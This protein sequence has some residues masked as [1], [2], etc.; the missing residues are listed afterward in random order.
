[1][2]FYDCRC[3]VTGVSLKG[4]GAALVLLQETGAGHHPLALP[5]QG[6]YNRLGAI[7]R[8]EEDANAALILRYFLD[9]LQRGQFVVDAE[10]LRPH[11]AFPIENIAQLFAA[12][13]RNINDNSRAAVLNGRPVVFALIARAVW[14]AVASAAPPPS[15]PASTVFQRL[16]K[17]VPAAE[18][19]YRGNVAKVTR[20]LQELSGVHQFLAG[21]GL[22][23][24]PAE[25]A[26]QHSPEEMRAYLDA[27]RQAFRDAP[28]A[29]QG[30]KQYE[31][32]VGEL[33][34]VG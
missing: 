3:M 26:S 22:T 23:W 6:V 15:A 31:A 14:G 13:E 33:L 34:K 28:A 30:L 17:G 11:N 16:F 10:Y 18:G 2:G 4:A 8:V 5:V 32:E 24:R 9:K 1:M 21:R 12:F 25:G 19:I 20:P 7:D 27:A 29:L